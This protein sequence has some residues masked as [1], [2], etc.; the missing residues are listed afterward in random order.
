[1]LK[2]DSALF[3]CPSSRLARS[4]MCSETCVRKKKKRQSKSPAAGTHGTTPADARVPGRFRC[5]DFSILKRHRSF[6]DLSHYD[7]NSFPRTHLWLHSV[8][9]HG[10]PVGSQVTGGEDGMQLL[11]RRTQI[12]TSEGHVRLHCLTLRL[13]AGVL[14]LLAVIKAFTVQGIFALPPSLGK[15]HKGSPLLQ[16]E[17]NSCGCPLP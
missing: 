10:E 6:W 7:R 17:L 16:K 13:D 2:T 14:R 11:T 15:V 4:A 1:M 8:H 12:S 3:L 9:I 5:N